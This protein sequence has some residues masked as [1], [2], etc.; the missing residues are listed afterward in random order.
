MLGPVTA[1][2]VAFSAMLFAATSAV[3]LIYTVK[4]LDP[5]DD[6]SP[7]EQVDEPSHGVM[8]LSA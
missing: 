1:Y 8:A 3:T 4:H 6:R 2:A 7:S 5:P